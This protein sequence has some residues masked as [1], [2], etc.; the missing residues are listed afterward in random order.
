[1]SPKVD[2]LLAASLSCISAL[3]AILEEYG[4]SSAFFKSVTKKRPTFLLRR[5]R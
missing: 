5:R 4:V 2:Y 3:F 1:M